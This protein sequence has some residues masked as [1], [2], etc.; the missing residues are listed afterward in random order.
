MPA[1]TGKEF[2]AGLKKP[3][4]V[5]VNG[6]RVTDVVSH[7]ALAGAAATLAEVYDLQHQAADICLMPD[8]ETGEP[9]NMSHMIP[10]S[11]EDLRRRHR[12]L[13]HIAE[14]TVGLMGPTI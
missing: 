11:R 10:R 1:R 14:Y 6:E 8:P 9:I 3:R 12:A 5:W 2:L 13:Q 7:P 4:H